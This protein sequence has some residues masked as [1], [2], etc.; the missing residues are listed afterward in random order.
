MILVLPVNSHIYNQK[1]DY[2]KKNRSIG[3]HQKLKTCSSKN[4]IKKAK[5][6]LQKGW[7]YRNHTCDKGIIFR[8]YKEILQLNNKNIN[9]IIKKWEQDLMGISPEKISKWPVSTL[10]DV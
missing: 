5:N 8:L 2:Q 9:N 10:K 7:T 1:H 3:L 4:I 6:N